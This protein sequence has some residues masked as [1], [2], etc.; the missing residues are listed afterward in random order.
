M[1]SAFLWKT[2]NLV[3]LT[4]KDADGKVERRVLVAEKDRDRVMLRE[5]PEGE[6]TLDVTMSHPFFVPAGPIHL[7]VSVKLERGAL[8]RERV[9]IVSVGGAVAFEASSGAAR[10]T[11]RDGVARI[12]AAKD[13]TI[14][15]DGVAP[16]SY[17][18]EMCED[19]ACARVVRRWEGVQ[20]AR[21]RRVVLTAAP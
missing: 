7:S 3:A 17:A 15:I 21:E 5:L 10:L 13:G 19:A 4:R 2:R 14:A 12:A 11:G 1:K 18:V 9:E 6:W 16:G 20:V 8:V